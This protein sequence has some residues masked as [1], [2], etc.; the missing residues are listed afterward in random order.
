MMKLL[1]KIWRFTKRPR[2]RQYNYPPKLRKRLFLNLLGLNLFVAIC[3][4]MIMGII[5]TIT[6]I[7]PGEH[8]MD[9]LFEEPPLYVFFLAIILAPL[10]EETIFRGPLVWFRNWKYFPGAFYASVLLFGGIHLFNFNEYD[11]VLWAAPLLVAPQLF[12]GI[13]LGYTRIKMGLGYS[14]L[15]HACFN[16]VLLGPLIILQTLTPLFE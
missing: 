3:L 2:Y 5:E 6:A 8:M 1:Q 16:A 11:Q 7:D 14:I 10:I 12:S 4:G 9:A 13:V 15:M